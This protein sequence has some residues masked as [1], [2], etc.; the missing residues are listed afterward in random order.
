MSSVPPMFSPSAENEVAPGIHST[1]IQGLYYIQYKKFID[2]RGFFSDITGFKN[3][4]KVIGKRM[5]IK[6]INFASSHTNVIRGLHSEGW[7]KLVTVFSGKAFSALVDIRPESPTFKAI[8][9]FMFDTDENSDLGTSL[10]IP[11]G[12]SNSVCAIEGPVS[13][14]YAVDAFYDERD[15]NGDKA[16]SVFDPELNL[17]WPIPREQ[18]IISE[19]DKESITLQEMLKQEN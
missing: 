18:M 4:E 8:E 15:P 6:Q 16:L 13:Y 11:M 12:V 2:N 17:Q 9:Y 7:N 14:H 10:Y 3:L 1:K 5:D 19:R